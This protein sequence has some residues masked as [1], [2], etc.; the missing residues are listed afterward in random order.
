MPARLLLPHTPNIPCSLLRLQRGRRPRR[1]PGG[2]M[3]RRTVRSSQYWGRNRR[4]PSSP[5]H[6]AEVGVGRQEGEEVP[7]MGARESQ[8]GNP[9]D[10]R[11]NIRPAGTK[12]QPN[13]NV[14]L[15][16]RAL[17]LRAYT[18]MQSHMSMNP[19]PRPPC[20]T[21]RCLASRRQPHCQGPRQPLAWRHRT[22]CC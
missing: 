14:C 2:S 1:D 16:A 8:C 7:Y 21:A 10:A 5:Q 12:V 9:S 20:A 22:R 15:W 18:P 19:T 11:F 17:T 13:R 3:Q 4:Q 6:P